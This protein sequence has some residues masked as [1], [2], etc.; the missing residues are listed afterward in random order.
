MSS[1]AHLYTIESVWIASEPFYLVLVIHK[2]RLQR[3]LLRLR[4]DYVGLE[5][6]WW[7]PMRY[8]ARR[9]LVRSW[10][11]RSVSYRGHWGEVSI[12][13]DLQRGGK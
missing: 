4:Q 7:E 5:S 6:R 10:L 13:Y 9:D 8:A 12:T 2:K 3:L 11:G 1:A